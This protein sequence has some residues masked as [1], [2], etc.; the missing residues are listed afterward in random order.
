M[1]EYIYDICEMVFTQKGSYESH[2]KRKRPCKKDSTPEPLPIK[3]EGSETKNQY[4]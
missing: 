1:T 3:T 4:G 2:K